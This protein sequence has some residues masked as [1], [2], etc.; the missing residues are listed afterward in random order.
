MVVTNS[1]YSHNEI[2]GLVS[3]RY[4]SSVFNRMGSVVRTTSCS[5]MGFRGPIIRRRSGPVRGRKPGLHYD[6]GTIST[7]G[8]TNFS[9][10]ALTGGRLCSCNSVNITS[11]LRMLSSGKFSCIKNKGGVARTSRILCGKVRRGGLTV[12]GYYRRRFSVTASYV[13][14]TGPLG[15]VRRCCR[16]RRTGGGTSC[17]LIVVRNNRRRFRLPSLQVRRACHFCV[18]SNTSTVMGRRRRYFDNCRMCGKGPVFCNLKGFYFS[19][20]KR[21][22]SV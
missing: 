21:T 2:T 1:F 9:Y 22:C 10:I 7:V 20:K 15:P 11:A 3:G 14:N 18:S 12:V 6:T 13:T 8:C 19:G 16:V 5:V 4:C 17:I